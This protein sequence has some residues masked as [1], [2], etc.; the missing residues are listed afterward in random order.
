LPP[1]GDWKLE[2]SAM[3]SAATGVTQVTVWAAFFGI[4]LV[5]SALGIIALLSSL[6][7]EPDQQKLKERCHSSGLLFLAVGLVL[8]DSLLLVLGAALLL[9]SHPRVNLAA[10]SRRIDKQLTS[11]TSTH[12]SR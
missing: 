5:V 11:T 8:Q 1:I 2:K 4:L 6:G 9:I 7:L 3:N 12:T 10:F